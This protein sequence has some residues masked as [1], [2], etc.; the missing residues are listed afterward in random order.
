MPWYGSVRFEERYQAMV[1]EYDRKMA[2]QRE[3]V[4]KLDE[5]LAL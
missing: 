3:L 1:E 2:E 4:S 5:A